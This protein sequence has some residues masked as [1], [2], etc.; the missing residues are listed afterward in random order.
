MTQRLALIAFATFSMLALGCSKGPAERLSGKWAGESIDNIPTG[1]QDRATG[2]VRSTSLEFKGDKLTVNVPAEEP[3]TGTYRVTRANGNKMTLQIDRT[4]GQRDEAT[5]TI[6][7]EGTMKWD[8]GNERSI[9][10][11]RVAMR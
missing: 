3:R 6:T 8:I 4:D 7:G 1:Q 9:R 2:W 10:L 11:V 5:F